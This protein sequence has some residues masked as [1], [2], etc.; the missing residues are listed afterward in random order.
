MAKTTESLEE[1]YKHKFNE[2]S[3]NL[4]RDIGQFNVFNIEDQIHSNTTS[5]T[6]IRRD[7]FKKMLFQGN[8]VFH[9]GDKSIAVNGNTLLFFNPQ[10][11]YTYD[12]LNPETKGDFCVFKDEF[13]KVSTDT[14]LKQLLQ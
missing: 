3:E 4:K 10:V 13:F 7:F 12:S 5:P 8:N 2:L 1:F 6:N 11:P 14:L 9:Y